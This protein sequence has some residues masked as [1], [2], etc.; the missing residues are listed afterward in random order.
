LTSSR[1]ANSSGRRWK[2]MHQ[3]MPFLQLRSSRTWRRQNRNLGP[4]QQCKKQ[5]EELLYIQGIYSGPWQPQEI[6]KLISIERCR[7]D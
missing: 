6:W 1:W 4:P 5:R 7:R 3:K 2:Q